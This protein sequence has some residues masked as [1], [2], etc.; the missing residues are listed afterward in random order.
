MLWRIPPRLKDKKRREAKVRENSLLNI[1]VKYIF[2]FPKTMTDGSIRHSGWYPRHPGATPVQ[3]QA[4]AAQVGKH[5][6][7]A[8]ARA[9]SDPPRLLHMQRQA[10]EHG[11][12]IDR[13]RQPDRIGRQLHRRASINSNSK[14]AGTSPGTLNV[15]LPSVLCKSHLSW[16]TTLDAL[17]LD[18]TG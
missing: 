2:L 16:A 14:L 11:T 1:G 8:T 12:H 17:W 10:I 15:Q 9:L 7:R 3:L 18:C 4:R 5:V 6:G 13:R